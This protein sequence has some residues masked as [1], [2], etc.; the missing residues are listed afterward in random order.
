MGL[1]EHYEKITLERCVRPKEAARLLGALF[2][3]PITASANIT[4]KDEYC[5]IAVT[6]PYITEALLAPIGVA[7][8]A[9]FISFILCCME[10]TRTTP[11]AQKQTNGKKL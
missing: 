3:D 9:V 11:K 2:L 4:L 5:I 8:L 7:F 6:N 1:F 10:P